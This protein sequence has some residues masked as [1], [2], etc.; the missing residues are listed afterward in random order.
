M[1]VE[2]GFIS[3]AAD[4]AVYDDNGKAYAENIAKAVYEWLETQNSVE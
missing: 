3:S 4:N 1:I 2:L